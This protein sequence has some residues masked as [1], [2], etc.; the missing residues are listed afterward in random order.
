[1]N[2]IVTPIFWHIH[3]SIISPATHNSLINISALKANNGWACTYVRVCMCVSAS[4]R[5]CIA[6]IHVLSNT[7]FIPSG[8]TSDLGSHV[9][10]PPSAPL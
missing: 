2:G 4:V 6:H 10:T 9:F 8:K 7:H 1:M 5:V 3:D